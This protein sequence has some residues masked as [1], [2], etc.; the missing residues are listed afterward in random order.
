MKR[1]SVLTILLAT[2]VLSVADAV[3]PDDDTAPEP[4]QVKIMS[5][6]G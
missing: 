4:G 3:G 5:D 6:E 1:L 2:T